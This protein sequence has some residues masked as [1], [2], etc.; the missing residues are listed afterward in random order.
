MDFTEFFVHAKVEHGRGFAA[1]S[2]YALLLTVYFA[3][4]YS[5]DRIERA[6][7]IFV[8]VSLAAPLLPI[9]FGSAVE[10]LAVL[11]AGAGFAIAAVLLAIEAYNGRAESI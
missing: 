4:G 10:R 11:L 1:G 6:M 5:A 7:W 2:L 8:T 9:V 3:C